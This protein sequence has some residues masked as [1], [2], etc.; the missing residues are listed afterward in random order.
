VKRVKTE[1]EWHNLRDKVITA[2]Q[3]PSIFGLNPY[4]SVTKMWEEKFNSTFTGNAYTDVGEWLEPVIV[5]TTNKVLGRQFQLF[6]SEGKA[7]YMNEEVRL[8]ATPDATDGKVLL[9]CK[10]TGPHNALKWAYFPPYHYLMQLYIQL[11]CTDMEEGYL[12]ILGTNLAQKSQELRL[13]LSI[14]S[15]TKDKRVTIIIEKEMQ[16]FWKC[17]EDNKRFRVNRRY[18]TMI[19]WIFRMNLEKLA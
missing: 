13:P 1:E 2:T 19:K 6:E 3:A 10:S 5:Q 17:I 12:A 8:G 9:E 14:F 16:R 11:Y 18:T 7:F 4:K 15:L